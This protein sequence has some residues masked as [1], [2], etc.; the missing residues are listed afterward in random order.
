MNRI[1]HHWTHW[2]CVEAGMYDTAP[3]EGMSTD[4]AL[5]AYGRVIGIE[6]YGQWADK[7]QEGIWAIKGL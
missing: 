6:P 7:A 2:E 4:E 5:E 3:P 1:Y